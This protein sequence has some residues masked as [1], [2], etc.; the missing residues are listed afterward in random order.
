MERGMGVGDMNGNE[1]DVKKPKDENKS[2]EVVIE[3]PKTSGMSV[4][5]I[6]SRSE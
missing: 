3:Q 5:D 2:T 1:N 6:Y 4:S